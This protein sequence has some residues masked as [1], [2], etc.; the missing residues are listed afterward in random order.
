[1]QPHSGIKAPLRAAYHGHVT[2]LAAKLQASSHGLLQA[3]LD[4]NREW[5]SFKTEY[6]DKQLHL[7]DR[8]SWEVD[9]PAENNGPDDLTDAANCQMDVYSQADFDNT[10]VCSPLLH[11]RFVP[12]YLPPHTISE[13]R[14]CPD[15]FIS[16]TG[17][18]ENRVEIPHCT[19]R[20]SRHQGIK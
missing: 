9:L 1:M 12:L 5:Q 17:K 11:A 18:F 7:E 8:N 3:T 14:F 10:E 15:S 2:Q 19:F 20:H 6:L 16:S 13:A 4:M